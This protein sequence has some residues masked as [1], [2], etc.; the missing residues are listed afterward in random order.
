ME[1]LFTLPPSYLP[2][3]N[4]L[5]A[6][7]RE[8]LLVSVDAVRPTTAVPFQMRVIPRTLREREDATGL[9]PARFDS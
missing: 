1:S 6:C 3:W 4:A 2:C 9:V 7:D 5:L 8:G